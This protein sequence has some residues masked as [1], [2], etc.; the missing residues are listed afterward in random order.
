MSENSASKAIFEIRPARPGDEGVIVELIHALSVY[1]K[2]EDQCVVTPEA[3]RAHVFGERPAAEVLIAWVGTEAVAFALYFT[4]FSTF[5]GKPG[6]Y[7]EDLFVK[8]Q[9]R[10]YGIGTQLL[11]EL[12]RI[13]LRRDY[14]RM[15]WSVLEWNELAKDRYRKIGAVPLDDWR[16]WRMTVPV[17]HEFLKS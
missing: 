6:L 16:I 17:L 14:G 9:Y 3:I 2:M 12:A 11:K 15:E 8:P 5:L 7:L 13:A 10:R 4:N 1:E